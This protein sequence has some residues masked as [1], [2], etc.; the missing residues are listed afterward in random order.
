MSIDPGHDQNQ[1]L[2]VL[3]VLAVTEATDL[4]LIPRINKH[5]VARGWPAAERKS[6]AAVSMESRP[7]VTSG[8]GWCWLASDGMRTEA[9]GLSSV[10]VSS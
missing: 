4:G 2:S 9:N 10:N 5:T 7:L 6:T 1:N 3:S 8:L